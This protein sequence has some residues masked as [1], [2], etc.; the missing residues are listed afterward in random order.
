MKFIKNFKN[1]SSNYED[2]SMNFFY[3]RD[4]EFED[5]AL[6]KAEFNTYCKKLKGFAKI[7]KNYSAIFENN[8]LNILSVKYSLSREFFKSI[9]RNTGVYKFMEHI[10]IEI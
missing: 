7:N 6:E 5:F 4:V 1:A 9:E 3:L 8:F 2:L 10:Y